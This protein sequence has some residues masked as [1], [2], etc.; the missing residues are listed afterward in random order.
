[1]KKNF[2][3]AILTFSTLA[4]LLGFGGVSYNGGEPLHAIKVDIDVH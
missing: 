1:M 2:T 3:K 4:M